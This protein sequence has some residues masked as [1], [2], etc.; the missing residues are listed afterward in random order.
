[1]PWKRRYRKKKGK[2][3]SGKP[4]G[5]GFTN[6]ANISLRRFKNVT[7]PTRLVRMTYFTKHVFSSALSAGTVNYWDLQPFQTPSPNKFAA[8]G[9]PDSHSIEYRWHDQLALRY[10]EYQPY[11]AH[12]RVWGED[13]SN[14]APGSTFSN[15]YSCQQ[16]LGLLTWYKDSNGVDIVP[17]YVVDGNHSE[18]DTYR[19]WPGG[20]NVTVPNLRNARRSKS[21]SAYVRAKDFLGTGGLANIEKE[22]NPFDTAQRGHWPNFRIWFCPGRDQNWD[23]IRGDGIAVCVFITVYLKVRQMYELDPLQN[24]T[25]MAVLRAQMARIEQK[26]KLQTDISLQS[27]VKKRRIEEVDPLSSES[28]GRDEVDRPTG[29]LQSESV[30]GRD[31]IC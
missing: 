22:W 4:Q 12:I 13:I 19:A 20:R 5:L 29:V 1:M 6:R 27:D 31:S 21:M 14:V 28:S 7:A 16:T 25:M 2:R 23:G 26:K 11:A 10:Q 3:A 15:L 30:D 24:D 9:F 18:L 8:G 17:T